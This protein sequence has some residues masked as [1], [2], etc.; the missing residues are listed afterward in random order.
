MLILDG[1]CSMFSLTEV[2]KTQSLNGKSLTTVWNPTRGNLFYMLREAFGR[3]LEVRGRQSKLPCESSTFFPPDCTPDLQ[4]P[5]ANMSSGGFLWILGSMNTSLNANFC[6]NGRGESWQTHLPFV[7]TVSTC[8]CS[9]TQY[10]LL[11]C[12]ANGILFFSRPANLI[13]NVRIVEVTFQIY[14]QYFSKIK[15]Q[16]QKQPQKMFVVPVWM[17]Y[18]TDYRNALQLK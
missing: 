3:S 7:Q 1:I 14:S 11:S 12:S 4:K 5:S 9:N 8:F 2:K 13:M 15:Q 10:H 18:L 16:Q 17:Y 6:F